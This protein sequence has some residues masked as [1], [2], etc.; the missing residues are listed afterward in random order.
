MFQKNSK[1]F[2]A[3]W[4]DLAKFSNFGKFLSSLGKI[5]EFTL[6]LVKLLAFCGKFYAIGQIFILANAQFE[7]FLINELVTLL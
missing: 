3:V 2:Q 7:H 5:F 1:N 6:H 4:P